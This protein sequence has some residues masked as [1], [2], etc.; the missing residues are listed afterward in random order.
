M[1]GT[2]PSSSTPLTSNA[3]YDRLPTIFDRLAAKGVSG[4]FYVENLDS[5][6]HQRHSH[7]AWLAPASS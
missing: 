6:Q 5:A 1:S 2:A 7:E 4:K 3:G